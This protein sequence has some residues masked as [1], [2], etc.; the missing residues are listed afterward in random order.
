MVA[1]L[2][3]LGWMPYR[4]S[5][6]TWDRKITAK[7]LPWKSNLAMPWIRITREDL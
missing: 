6:V 5:L 1:S 2:L 3:S 7:P 4:F